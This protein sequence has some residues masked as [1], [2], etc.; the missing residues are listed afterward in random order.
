MPTILDIIVSDASSGGGSGGLLGGNGGGGAGGTGGAGGSGGAGG[1]AT[2]F[3]AGTLIRC[4]A[5]D[6]AVENLSVGDLVVTVSGE[7]RPVRWIG[8]RRIKDPAREQWPVRVMTAAFGRDAPA[9]DLLLSPGHAVCVYVAGEVLVPVGELVNGVS[10]VR[11]AAAEVSYWHVELESHDVLV[12][13]G[14]P[15]E[16]Y[17]DTGNRE[18]F[19]R[20]Y[21]RLPTVDSDRK[22][23]LCDSCRPFVAEGPIVEAI[24]EQLSA[25]A[26]AL[27]Y[28]ATQLARAQR[29]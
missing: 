29:G 19:G 20:A 2:C 7:T 24:R 26:V 1:G 14:L 21:G 11:E 25:R 6:V 28:L 9:R 13:E 3:C 5:G 18:W 12:A 23:T 16:S 10:V 27:G 4:A 17:L 8:S 22:L 15:C